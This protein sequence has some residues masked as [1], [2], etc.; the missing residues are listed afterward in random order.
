MNEDIK[1]SDHTN[2]PFTFEY[3][4]MPNSAPQHLLKQTVQIGVRRR[5]E[6]VGRRALPH[7]FALQ[8]IGSFQVL[9]QQ[10]VLCENADDVI[11]I[12]HHKSTHVLVEKGLSCL[13]H[14]CVLT[15]AINT[16]AFEPNYV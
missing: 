12:E 6:E 3:G 16:V 11:A 1:G 7:S 15:D 4:D 13:A 2:R 9:P 8:L 5:G 10:I 14:G